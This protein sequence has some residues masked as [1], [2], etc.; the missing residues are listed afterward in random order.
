LGIEGE[1]R[2]GQEGRE[3]VPERGQGVF[4]LIHRVSRGSTSD[5]S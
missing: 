5:S 3:D 2:V 1:L 4:F